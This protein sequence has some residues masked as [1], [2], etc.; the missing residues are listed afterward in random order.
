LVAGGAIAG[1]HVLARGL[2]QIAFGA[3]NLTGL[4][5]LRF[6]EYADGAAQMVQP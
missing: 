4:M 2:W 1:R 6:A 3:G 5:G